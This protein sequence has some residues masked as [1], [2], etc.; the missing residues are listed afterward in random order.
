MKQRRLWKGTRNRELCGFEGWARTGSL[1][2][3]LPFLC[4]LFFK[5]DFLKYVYTCACRCSRKPVEDIGSPWAG[6]RGGCELPHVV[7]GNQTEVLWKSKQQTFLSPEH[8]SHRSSYTPNGCTPSLPLR[9][10]HYNLTS[11]CWLLGCFWQWASIKETE[12]YFVNEWRVHVCVCVCVC[13]RARVFFF[14]LVC[15]CV[16]HIKVVFKHFG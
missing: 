11:N 5:K 13:V 8:P 16:W 4:K 1:R 3:E 10:L 14:F 6:V 7:A 2:L 15:V 12:M 9:G